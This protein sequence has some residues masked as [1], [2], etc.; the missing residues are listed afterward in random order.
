MEKQKA[1]QEN[2]NKKVLIDWVRVL[3]LPNPKKK[4][5]DQVLEEFAKDILKYPMEKGNPFSWPT[6]AGEYGN[7]SAI[8]V[9]ISYE[10]WKFFMREGRK[11]L[12]EYNREHGTTIIISR[13]KTL[14]L[15]E[16]DRLGLYLRKKIKQEYAKC[17]KNPPDI[18]M[19]KGA[20]RIGSMEPMKPLVAAIRLDVDMSDWNG[21]KLEDMLTEKKQSAM[22]KGELAFGT[23]KLPGIELS[24]KLSQVDV[25]STSC[26]AA[27]RKRSNEDDEGKRPVKQLK[28]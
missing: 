8:R 14:S 20:L 18:T 5:Y 16:Q 1:F 25:P 15:Q 23:L 6:Y 10:F 28:K 12:Y 13:E 9:R 11:V 19:S 7:H 27:T 17:K 2:I 22:E 21:S 26:E 24:K 4:K 3:G